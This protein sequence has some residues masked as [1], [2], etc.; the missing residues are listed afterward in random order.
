MRKFLLVMLVVCG[1]GKMEGEGTR[2][3]GDGGKEKKN[4]VVVPKAPVA[5]TVKESVEKGEG[6]V[7]MLPFDTSAIAPGN[8]VGEVIGGSRWKDAS[9]ENILVV[10][11]KFSD[12][13]V[14]EDAASHQ[15][16]GALYR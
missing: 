3:L 2:G 16:R 7:A 12:S 5:E 10:S 9:G 15:I 1:C 8:I 14:I 13:K 4:E 6:G 11:Q